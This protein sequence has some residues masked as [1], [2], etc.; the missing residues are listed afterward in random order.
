MGSEVLRALDVPEELESTLSASQIRTV[1]TDT[2]LFPMKVAIVAIDALPYPPLVTPDVTLKHDQENHAVTSDLAIFT[3]DKVVLDHPFKVDD[4]NA[5]ATKADDAVIPEYL[6]D[7]VITPQLD[8]NIVSALRVMC[9]LALRW[10]NVHL[11]VEFFQW[12]TRTYPDVCISSFIYNIRSQN[13]NTQALRDWIAGMDCLRRS[14]GSSWW[15]WLEESRPYCWHWSG[16]YQCIIRD[17]LPIWEQN[18]LPRLLVRQRAEK[19]PVMNR[20]IQKK[21]QTVRNRGYLVPGTVKS[22][23]SLFA[24]RKGDTDIRIVYDSTKSGLNRSVWAPWFPLPT[25]EAH[26]YRVEAGTFMGGIDIGEM[27]LN[28]MLH[29]RMQP[30]AG[31]YITPFFPEELAALPSS[32]H[33]LWLHWV[34]CG[35]GFCFSPYVAVQGILFAEEIVRGN[36]HNHRN[37]FRWDR[38]ILNLPGSATYTPATSWVYKVRVD[39]ILASDFLIYV[40]DVRTMGPSAEDCRLASRQVASTLNHLGLQDAARKRRGGSQTPGAWAGSI[41]NTSDGFISVSVSQA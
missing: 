12:F 25:I 4:R 9:K 36:H 8:P 19:D 26:L 14:R 24:V 10:W 1:C 37:A 28:F 16:E 17:G 29:P 23:T 35:M 32:H 3:P 33:T 41:V 7:Q 27:F 5:T 11:E 13:N 6:W 18:N 15:E 40:D 39:G 34:R 30:Y 20:A 21:L 38:V 2:Q 31:V 22:L